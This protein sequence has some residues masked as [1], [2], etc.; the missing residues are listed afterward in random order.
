MDD[1]YDL[2]RFVT[3]QDEGGVYLQALD[4]LRR[5][6]KESHWMWFVFPQIAGLGESPASSWFAIG[7][8]E[9]AQAY[10][11]HPVLG[12][13]LIECANA[14]AAHEG[15]TANEI[16]GSVDAMKLRSSMTLFREATRDQP[17]FDQVLLRYFDGAA[18]PMTNQLL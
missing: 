13:R 6:R 17:V 15:L 12:R 10:M 7:S 14:V 11:R 18:D 2:E 4:E 8:L 16:F 5:G 3:A 1:P 9:E